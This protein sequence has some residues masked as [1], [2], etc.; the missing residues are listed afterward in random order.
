MNTELQLEILKRVQDEIAEAQAEGH[1][2]VDDWFPF[3]DD[4]DVNI[5]TE[6]GVTHA[7]VYPKDGDDIG[8]EI[9]SERLTWE[10]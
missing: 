2:I 4:L 3:D 8:T 5:W 10:E 7:W 1:V 9:F 6:N